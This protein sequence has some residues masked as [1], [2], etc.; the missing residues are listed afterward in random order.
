M[1]RR[2]QG[3][4]DIPMKIILLEAFHRCRGENLTTPITY[5]G[6]LSGSSPVQVSTLVQLR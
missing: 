3:L 6:F 4:R 2:R 5:L 1:R